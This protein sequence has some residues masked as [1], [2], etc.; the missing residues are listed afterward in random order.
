M[1]IR[2]MS[3]RD[4]GELIRLWSS[5][6][7]NAITGADSRDEFDAFLTKNGSFCFT[8]CEQ[9]AVVGSV[10]AGSDGRRGYVYHLAVKTDHQRKGLGGALMRRVEDALSKAGLEKI[11]LFIF[12]DNPAVAFY[13]KSGWHV[14]NDITV[15][16]RV[17][18]IPGEGRDDDEGSATG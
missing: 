8:A 11:H 13:E 5:F 12:S 10:M 15:M 6:P 9:D 18:G 4:H 2:A 17:L 7:G 3:S 1:R 14:R 16:S